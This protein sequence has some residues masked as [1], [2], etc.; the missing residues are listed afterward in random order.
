MASRT[1]RCLSRWLVGV[2]GFGFRFLLVHP[3]DEPADPG[4]F[5]TA[6]PRWEAGDTF[7]AGSDLR[8]FRILDVNTENPP[9]EF[10]SVS[11]R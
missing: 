9:E 3:D 10:A 5:V 6:I 7:P 4:M 8:R 2:V 1:P 11:S